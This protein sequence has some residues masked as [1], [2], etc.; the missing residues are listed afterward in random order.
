VA[1]FIE[2]TIAYNREKPV[3]FRSGF[4][5][6]LVMADLSGKSDTSSHFDDGVSFFPL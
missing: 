5:A 3:G 4:D 6:L 1:N 2:F